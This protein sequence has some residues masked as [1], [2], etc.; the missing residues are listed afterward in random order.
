MQK[1]QL[2][3]HRT[4]GSTP[5]CR[6]LLPLATL[7]LLPATPLLRAQTPADPQQSPTTTMHVYENL[8]QLPVLVLSAKQ[9][10]MKPVDPANFRVR[11]DSSPSFSPTYVR[12]EGDEPIELAIVIDLSK[13]D[14]ELLPDLS[15]SIAALAP[16]YLKP[17]DLVSVYAVDCSFIR[18]DFEVPADPASLKTS[19][20]RALTP[21]RTIQSLKH[22]PPPCKVTFPLWDAMANVLDDID[23]RSGHRVMLVITDGLDEGS[24]TR[25]PDVTKQA[26]IESVAVF[27]IRSQPTI[28]SLRAHEQGYYFE[29][30]RP[31]LS[32]PPD[33]FRPICELSGGIELQTKRSNLA[34]QLQEAIQMVR[35]RYIL[36]FPRD[37]TETPGVHGLAVTYLKTNFYIRPS[38]IAVPPATEE[39]LKGTNTLHTDPTQNP[40]AAKSTAPPPTQ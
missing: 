32:A 26:Q 36:E 20:D 14:S 27:G 40:P 13:S 11:I 6:S 7:L 18:A 1:I 30:E 37:P 15:Q 28:S 8:K 29:T 5:L 21:W 33:D 31:D 2:H 39:E 9:Q 4:I 24:R 25:W 17:Q 35:E 34:T 16:T 23:Q 3:A 38:G 12:Q 10:R 22:P 19:V